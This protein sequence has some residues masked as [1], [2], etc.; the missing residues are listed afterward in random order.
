[1]QQRPGVAHAVWAF[2]TGAERRFSHWYVNFQD[3]FARTR[4]GFDTFDHELDL[5]VEL[6]GGYRWKDVEEFERMV[7]DGRWTPAETEAI[8]AEA[9]RVADGLDRGE[10]WW[11]ESWAEWCPPAGW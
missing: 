2:W 10:R 9:R 7:V 8:R 6:D 4:D 1:M 11:D 3:P 5:V